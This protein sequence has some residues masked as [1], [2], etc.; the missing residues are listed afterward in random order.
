[1]RSLKTRTEV[2][3]SEE[4][5]IINHKKRTKKTGCLIYNKAHDTK[6]FAK[7]V[8]ISV[9]DSNKNGIPKEID[10]VDRVIAFSMKTCKIS[11]CKHSTT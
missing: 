10:I 5:E 7:L 2:Q 8:N 6:D 11:G 4:F 3:N 1:M 9:E